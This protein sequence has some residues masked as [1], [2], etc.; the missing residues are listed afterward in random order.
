MIS[1]LQECFPLRRA[2]VPFKFPSQSNFFK[3]RFRCYRI[4]L[5]FIRILTF[6][7]RKDKYYCLYFS[8][9]TLYLSFITFCDWHFAIG[10]HF[11]CINLLSQKWKKSCVLW[12]NSIRI[13][14]I[15]RTLHGRLGT[16]I[17]FSRAESISQSQSW[18]RYLQYDQMKLVFP[19]TNVMSSI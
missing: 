4:F 19:S 11:N 12:G 2:Q 6:W 3:L 9:I 15:N 18:E 13:Y 10:D 8:F 1:H 7:S 17:L 16:R 5:Y 14:K